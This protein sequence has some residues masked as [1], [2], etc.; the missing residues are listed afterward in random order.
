M[1]FLKKATPLYLILFLVITP[2][3][4]FAQF[5]IPR[6]GMNNAASR[7]LMDKAKVAVVDKLKDIRAENDSAT[8]SYAIALSDNAGQFEMKETSQR[9]QNAAIGYLQT[10]DNRPLSPQEEAT[11]Y[12]DAG[13]LLYAAHRYKEAEYSFYAAKSIFESHYSQTHVNYFKSIANLGLLF[14]TMGRFTKAEEYTQKA[15][16]LR[17]QN[18]GK[19]HPAYAASINNLAMLKKDQGYYSEAENLLQ[20][21][22]RINEASLGKESLPYAI[23]LNNEAMLLL[24]LGRAEQAIEMM[25]NALDIASKTMNPASGNYQRLQIN[26]GF[27]YQDLGK[28]EEAEK[29]YQEAIKLKEKRH[30]KK[31][32]DYAHLQNILAGLY[33]EMGKYDEVESLLKSAASIYEAKFGINHP[34]YAATASN[35]GKFY[36]YMGRHQEALPQFARTMYIRENI[37]GKNHPLFSD[38]QEDLAIAYWQDGQMDEAM[39][40]YRSVLQRSLEFV[41]TYFPPMSE[42]EKLKYWLRL[43]PKFE[44]FYAM[45]V[46]QHTAEPSLLIEM[47]NYQLATK[48][49]LLSSSGKVRT[50]VMQSGDSILMREY[51]QWLDAKETLARFYSYTKEELKEE[52]INLDSL[53]K[54][55]NLLERQLSQKSSA[56]AGTVKKEE[57]KISDLTAQL[58]PSEALVEII[59]FREFK[60]QKYGNTKYAALI[61]KKETEVPELVVLEN[62]DELEGKYYKYY[63]NAIRQKIKDEYTYQQY[64]YPIASK[65]NSKSDVYVSLD[66][67]Y[68]QISL[69]TLLNPNG[70]F[71]LEEKNLRILTNTKDIINLKQ[72]G[73]QNTSKSRQV[74]L[75][76]FPDYGDPSIVDPLP[77]TKIE[78]SN[79]QKV[80]NSANFKTS[81]MI[82][83]NAN[84]DAL[85]N[86]NDPLILHIATHGYFLS[87]LSDNG[88]ERVFGIQVDKAKNNPLLRSGLMM[89]GAANAIQGGNKPGMENE[90]GLF[91]AYEATSL[92]LE[93]TEL[94]ILSAC[95]TGLGDMVTGEGVFG[96]QR[97]FLV[98]GADALIMSLWKVNDEATQELMT[99]FMRNFIRL[100]NKQKAFSEAQIALKKKYPHPYFWGAFV[101]IGG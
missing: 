48:A 3:L 89:S 30:N 20:E 4:L 27:L 56:F 98:A 26:L 50:Q 7:I 74:Y 46:D 60:N 73:Q 11:K 23:C 87:E 83:E 22:Q 43:R 57:I 29:I 70:K 82:G 47:Y 33:M 34:S 94:V 53:E 13:E 31:H 52:N 32:P 61:L 14:H 88:E 51:T 28:Y 66:G 9:M 67:V 95:E 1:N 40:L 19:D 59:H 77:G 97:A 93:K 86:I 38:A 63:R 54:A 24:T 76:G 10:K 99:L 78:L 21:A 55:S 65:L 49:L 12:V 42:S 100:N 64:W 44:R 17:A 80:L 91:T 84:E 92:N 45:A 79:V 68:N 96:L 75:I 72:K 6:G 58:S 39:P 62:G 85:K 8:F 101:M 18:L 41:E 25:K 5:N 81:M 16:D 2:N 36:S 69:N 15:L 37:Y 35:L 71:L 90:N